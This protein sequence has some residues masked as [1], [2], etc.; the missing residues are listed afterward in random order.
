MPTIDIQSYAFGQIIPAASLGPDFDNPGQTITNL[1]NNW[2]RG[3]VKYLMSNTATEW[4]VQT[5][6]DY[7]DVEVTTWG[8]Q[9]QIYFRMTDEGQALYF[10][11][12]D[13]TGDVG[14]HA[15]DGI[16]TGILD[17]QPTYN[18]GSSGTVIGS[19]DLA[20]IPGWAATPAAGHLYTFGLS[21]WEYY[22]NVDIGAGQVELAR[23]IQPF[24]GRTGKIG[25]RTNSSAYGVDTFIVTALAPV[26]LY[27]DPEEYIYDPRDFGCKELSTT[28]S[29]SASSTS[30][31]VASATGFEIGDPIIV[32]VGGEA[33][34]GLVGTSG[35]G[36]QWPALSYANA[37]A[38]EADTTQVDGKWAYDVDTGITKWWDD[39]AVEWKRTTFSG[40]AGGDYYS[41]SAHPYALTATITNIAGN[42]LTL[43]TAATT[44]T[45]DANVYYDCQ[46]GMQACFTPDQDPYNLE[47]DTPARTLVLP[48]GNFAMDG[49]IGYGQTNATWEVYGQ[50]RDETRIFSPRGAYNCSCGG[51][52]APTHQWHDFEIAGN[53]R[54]QGYRMTVPASENIEIERDSPA[55]NYPSG[56][57]LLGG[58]NNVVHDMRISNFAGCFV[59]CNFQQEFH[60]Y[61]VE[62]SLD[63]SPMVYLS[64]NYQVAD[65]TASTYPDLTAM[66]PGSILF[67]RCT[68]TCPQYHSA[69]ETFRSDGVSF[70]DCTALNGIASSNASGAFLFDNMNLQFDEDAENRYTTV[71]AED[72]CP[73]EAGD[74]PII[75]INSNINPPSVDMQLGGVIRNPTI[76][77]EGPMNLAG[78]DGPPA[79]IIP[80]LYNPNVRII[81]DPPWT[82]RSC[83][84]PRVGGYFESNITPAAGDRGLLAVNNDADSCVVTG[85]R[86][87]GRGEVS[88]GWGWIRS[89]PAAS[90]ITISNCVFTEHDSLGYSND[91]ITGSGTK[92][93]SGNMDHT[94]W[95]LVCVLFHGDP[96]PKSSLSFSWLM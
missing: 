92:T 49:G 50:G 67:E 7:R 89:G 47:W 26:T 76:V 22:I 2:G 86:V 31:T 32:E 39:V 37:A 18:P 88:N 64:W 5:T 63:N 30:L 82:E 43:D 40:A 53:F 74:N 65:S 46:P 93:L 23:G 90:D 4:T 17:A 57:G 6:A 91:G 60:C 78:N 72:F 80:N 94:E 95:A 25:L 84:A 71:Y 96:V 13:I 24:H 11:W 21:G 87:V 12:S 20:D 15:Q 73:Q 56:I 58:A 83:N 55:F 69:F 33:G 10:Y 75:N 51:S 85:I 66:T 77:L 38:R 54:S 41:A 62:G 45:T 27:S 35:V 68:S 19:W 9:G 14:L 79:F 34:L 48:A 59:S 42:V 81:A 3:S 52:S 28:G 8:R 1:G 16:D 70:V 36:G 29:I 61:D 44:S